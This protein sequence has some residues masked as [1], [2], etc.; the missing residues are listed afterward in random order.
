MLAP[1]RAALQRRGD[2]CRRAGLVAIFVLWLFVPLA[3]AAHDADLLPLNEP[4]PATLD[5]LPT[6]PCEVWLISSRCA[7][8]CG[9]LKR[10]T[11]ALRYWRQ[12]ECEPWREASLAEFLADDDPSTVTVFF[13]H[14][15]NVEAEDAT[16]MGLAWY[17]RVVQHGCAP[18]R[19]RFVIWSWPSQRELPRV[20]RDVRAKAPR[21]EA[22]GFYVAWVI[23]QMDPS[24]P[25]SLVG[26]SY[27]A[28]SIATAL[29][30]LG[31]GTWCHQRLPFSPSRR[32]MHAV[33]AAA[34]IDA[35]DLAPRGMHGQA[36]NV[37]DRVLV[38]VNPLD[39]VL[40]FYPRLEPRR[41]IP[42]MGS[43][44]VWGVRDPRIEQLD[45]RHIIGRHHDWRRYVGSPRLTAYMRSV[46]LHFDE[47]ALEWEQ[48]AAEA[49]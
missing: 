1:G 46:L 32:P 27:G 5:V 11:A 21:S 47:P 6:P 12:V 4:L 13:L 44:G 33:L 15:N 7:P 10:G 22:H 49:L 3:Q 2:Q 8:H 14:G 30:L 36:M 45:V 40:K 41:R 29:H 34:A 28:R 37:V 24:A 16:G 31:G 19:V 43:A 9:D 39:P 42:A 35:N 26:Y 17:R 38:F 23:A 20:V 18:C 48:D 25:V